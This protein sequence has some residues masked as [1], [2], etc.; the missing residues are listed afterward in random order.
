VQ[1]TSL[2]GIALLYKFFFINKIKKTYILQHIRYLCI[3][4]DFKE[5]FAEY[6]FNNNDLDGA[7]KIYYEILKDENYSSKKGKSKFQFYI[8]LCSMI[9]ERPTEIV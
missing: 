6:L 5:D 4:P 2:K 3:E 7:A 1:N 8:D 9:I